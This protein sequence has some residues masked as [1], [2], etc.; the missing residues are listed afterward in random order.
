M[1]I[2]DMLKQMELKLEELLSE[3]KFY[4]SDKKMIDIL[5]DAER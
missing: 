5:K 4:K 1:N 3:I 2:A